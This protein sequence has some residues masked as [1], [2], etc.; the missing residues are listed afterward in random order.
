MG[1]LETVVLGCES[2]KPSYF[3]RKGQS[4]TFHGLLLFMVMTVGEKVC[5]L[6]ERWR[7]VR[8]TTEDADVTTPAV[9]TRRTPSF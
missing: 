8:G 5:V 2:T 9:R 6:R 3:N 1:K 7:F 4:S